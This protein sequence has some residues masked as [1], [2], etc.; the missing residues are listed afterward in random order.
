MLDRIE[1]WVQ[2]GAYKTIA[3]LFIR[4]LIFITETKLI[5]NVRRKEEKQ[6][7]VHRVGNIFHVLILLT[8]DPGIRGPVYFRWKHI[9]A[10]LS[11]KPLYY[12]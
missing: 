8:I 9:L 10:L 12:F 6:T 5:N 2:S 1:I 4:S 7:G 3:S 11:T